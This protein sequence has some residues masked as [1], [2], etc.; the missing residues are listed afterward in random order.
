MQCDP[1]YEMKKSVQN[2]QRKDFKKM[3]IINIADDLS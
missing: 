1:D 3:E 2:A